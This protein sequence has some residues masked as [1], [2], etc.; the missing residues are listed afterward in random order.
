MGQ[1][2]HPTSAPI[3]AASLTTAFAGNV[4]LTV[5]PNRGLH[6]LGI[7]WTGDL[8]LEIALDG[9]NIWLTLPG[10]G[11]S[12][13]LCFQSVWE[14]FHPDDLLGTSPAVRYTG[15]IPS[16]GSVYWC[17]TYSGALP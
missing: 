3:A 11:V 6:S 13:A 9:V 5:S 15:T 10:S 4:L 8:P 2:L 17:A 1:I 14:D 16:V 12:G 7:I